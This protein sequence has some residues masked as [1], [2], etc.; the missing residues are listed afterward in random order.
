MLKT[1]SCL[2]LSIGTL[3]S[4]LDSPPANLT[5][6]ALANAKSNIV[7]PVRSIDSIFIR[8]PSSIELDEIILGADSL[9]ILKLI[10]NLASD[11]ELT[12]TQVITYLLEI[13][14]RVKSAIE[15]KRFAS[16]QLTVIINAAE[17]EVRRLEG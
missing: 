15:Q 11:E 4:I 5:E 14:G 12:C 8:Y 10:Q 3:A 16:E 9:A 1:L 6:A 13:D 17:R 7:T 2:L